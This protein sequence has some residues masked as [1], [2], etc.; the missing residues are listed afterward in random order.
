MELLVAT[1]NSHSAVMSDAC[2]A[3]AQLATSLGSSNITKSREGSMQL[4]LSVCINTVE[5][6]ALFATHAACL[7]V[8]ECLAVGLSITDAQTC[9]LASGVERLLE[10]RVSRAHASSQF[11]NAGNSGD[12]TPIPLLKRLHAL[13]GTH[14]TQVWHTIHSSLSVAPH[15]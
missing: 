12:H 2:L 14:A 10:D 15:Y 6:G 7:G 8:S 13:T 5:C 11:S 9:T 4:G 1:S 3:V